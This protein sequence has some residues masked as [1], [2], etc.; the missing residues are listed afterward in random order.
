MMRRSTGM[1]WPP[2]SREGSRSTS[3]AP[4]SATMRNSSFAVRP[5]SSFRRCGSCETRHLDEDAADALALDRRLGGAERVDAAADHLDR[6]LGGAPDALVDALLR[7]GEL[8]QA[9]RLLGDVEVAGAGLAEDGV[10][11]RLRQLAQ[12]RQEPLALGGLG[13]AK[14]HAARQRLD[15]ALERHAGLAQD[16]PDVVAQ[17][18]VHGA[19]EIG[20]VD[21]E[22]HVRAA[23]E[24]EAERDRPAS[25]RPRTGPSPGP[26]WA[27]DARWAGLSRFGAAS[28]Q[29]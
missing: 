22:E 16:A 5:R 8:D 17:L 12:L 26:S 20:L 7:E 28:R 29:P 2:A 4:G 18:D 11:D 10:G 13:D 27:S 24:V 15:A 23:L 6:L 1:R 25:A 9:V 19:Q 3:V 14:L 21:L